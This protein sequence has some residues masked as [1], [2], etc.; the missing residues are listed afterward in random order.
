MS[1]MSDPIGNETTRAMALSTQ[2]SHMRRMFK[3]YV[4]RGTGNDEITGQ[5]LLV[6]IR[7]ELKNDEHPGWCYCTPC[8][9]RNL[10][11]LAQAGLPALTR[12]TL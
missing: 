10:H 5:Y 3:P 11:E 2:D 4:Y 7:Q 9:R 12:S 8:T 6:K 1:M